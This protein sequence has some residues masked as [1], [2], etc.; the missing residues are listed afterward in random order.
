VLYRNPDN[1]VFFMCADNRACVR[2]R[3]DSCAVLSDAES[4]QQRSK[5]N[6]MNL[7]L[8]PAV[9]LLTLVISATP[10]PVF[11]DVSL[12]INIAPPELPVYEQP[13][14]PSEGYVWTPGYWAYAD[15]GYYWVPGA[16]ILP[17]Q[18]GFLWTPGYWDWNDG[19]YIFNNGYWGRSIGYYGGVN[20]GYGYGGRGYEGGRWNGDRFNYNLAVNHVNV[21]NV[22]NSY[23][24]N[25]TNNV[26]VNRVSF[27]GGTGGTQVRPTAEETAAGREQHISATPEQVNHEHIARS[28]PQQRQSVNQGRPPAAAVL[29]SSTPEQHRTAPAKIAAGY[30]AAGAHALH[31][32]RVVTLQVKTPARPERLAQQAYTSAPARAA[33]QKTKIQ[34][35]LEHPQPRPQRQEQH[36]PAERQGGEERH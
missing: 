9:A 19:F 26:T 32:A 5:E 30:P 22:H 33:P 1:T 27:N 21:E 20:Y 4:D 14:L 24:Q 13:I 28:N 8:P 18:V 34:T 12:S 7:K 10:L 2:H 23:T 15:N 17:P 31:S 29:R 25:V 35:S 36:Q 3:T 11:A 16:W 6:T